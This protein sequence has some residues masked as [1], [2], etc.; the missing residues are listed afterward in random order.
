MMGNNIFG[1]I[2]VGR[3]AETLAVAAVRSALRSKKLKLNGMD[4]GIIKMLASYIDQAM[5][6]ASYEIIE[7]FYSASSS[8]RM[9]LRRFNSLDAIK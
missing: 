5:E 9:V 6:L 1:E 3:T 4:T 7:D 8:S 2:V